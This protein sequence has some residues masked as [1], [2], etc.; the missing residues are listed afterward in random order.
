[1]IQYFFGENHFYRAMAKGPGRLIHFALLFKA[2][3][4]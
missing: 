4:M 2:A 3:R 1:M